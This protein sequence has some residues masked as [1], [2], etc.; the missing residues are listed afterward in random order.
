VA[1]SAPFS[2]DTR[3]HHRQRGVFRGSDRLEARHDA[4]DGAEQA[5]EGAREPTVASTRSR[6]SS[7]STSGR[8]RRSSL[9]R[10]ASEGRRRSATGSRTSASTRAW[11]LRNTPHRL[12]RF[13]ESARKALDR[14]PDQNACSKRSH[15]ALGGANTGKICR[16]RSPRPRPSRRA[17]EHYRFH[18]PVGL[19]NSAI[20]ETSDAGTASC[21]V[22]TCATAPAAETTPADS[23][24]QPTEGISGPPDRILSMQYPQIPRERRLPVFAALASGAAVCASARA[25]W[26]VA[27]GARPK[28]GPASLPT[29]QK[30][31]LFA[32]H[33]VP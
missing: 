2:A 23:P 32:R 30:R 11:Q 19:M 20:S 18:D 28:P 4:P 12:R 17:G 25:S 33:Y 5:D 16:S 24:A 9:S 26:G 6:R 10:S 31:G 27:W 15:G 7:R 21:C 3:G 1:N 29:C 14:L 22:S 8:S 13:A